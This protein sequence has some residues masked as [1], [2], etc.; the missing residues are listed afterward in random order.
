MASA[1]L[2][3][4]GGKLGQKWSGEHHSTANYFTRIFVRSLAPVRNSFGHMMPKAS[5][6]LELDGTARAST[7]TSAPNCIL[8]DPSPEALPAIDA[9]TESIPRAFCACKLLLNQ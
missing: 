1:K 3:L 9:L 7:L 6:G 4:G 8:R 5:G 2:D